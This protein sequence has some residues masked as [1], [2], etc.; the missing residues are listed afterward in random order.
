[1]S[2]TEAK[3]LNH[4]QLI[5]SGAAIFLI[6]T[7]QLLRRTGVSYSD[8]EAKPIY[9]APESFACRLITRSGS[10]SKNIAA[11]AREITQVSFTELYRMQ[12]PYELEINLGDVVLYTDRVSGDVKRFEVTHAPAKHKYTG[13]VIIFLQ[14][15]H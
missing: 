8:G 9:A 1:M 2:L 5:R 11:Q 7:A 10:E 4:I 14:E 13:A 12:I 6:D 3:L 15:Q